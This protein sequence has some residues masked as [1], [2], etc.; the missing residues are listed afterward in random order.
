MLAV[1]Q[2]HLLPLLLLVPFMPQETHRLR[3]YMRGPIAA[4]PLR[5][6]S[7]LEGILACFILP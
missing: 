6:P 4:L 1:L 5:K 2:S 7:F 3:N